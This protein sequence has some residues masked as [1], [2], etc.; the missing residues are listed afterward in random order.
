[1]QTFSGGLFHSLFISS[2][3]NVLGC[4]R[5]EKGSLGSV[6]K[7][8]IPVDLSFPPNI[9]SVAAGNEF[10][11]CLDREGNVW[12]TG[13]CVYGENGMKNPTT[14]PTKILDIPP[15]QSVV[16]SHNYYSVYLDINGNAWSCG[17]NGF[18]QLGLGSLIEQ[19]HPVQVE[20][21]PKLKSVAVGYYHTF[22][23]S[24]AGEV[25]ASGY[26]MYGQLG[27]SPDLSQQQL[28]PIK[29]EFPLPIVAVSAGDFHT[30]FLDIDG[31]V[32]G[33]GIDASSNFEPQ[34]MSQLPPIV[35]VSAGVKY[36][37]FLDVNG[38]VWNR[39]A[40]PGYPGT[41]NL[42]EKFAGV[43]NMQKLNCSSHL[44]FMDNNDQIWSAGSNSCG[45]LGLGDANFR[46]NPELNMQLGQIAG[47]GKRFVAT[48]SARKL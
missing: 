13:N 14:T 2:N 25:W 12:G 44:L 40:A 41:A 3:G 1:M 21:L 48:K 36:S 24:E 32:W 43:V 16:A 18:G 45:Q 23:I 38:Q 5:N 37:A 42:V 29:I 31:G 26:N 10:S 46:F 6:P 27:I 8:N 39:G 35:E 33:C 20:N 30:V 15:M 4:G 11:L 9:C 34:R 22:F 19:R 28:V 7:S 47:T 17:Y